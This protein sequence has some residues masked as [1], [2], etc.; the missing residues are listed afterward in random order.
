[1]YK[2]ELWCF[3]AQK[4]LLWK[5]I[6]CCYWSFFLALFWHLKAINDEDSFVFYFFFSRIYFFY[7]K[8]GLC[9]VLISTIYGEWFLIGIWIYY[10]DANNFCF[11][12]SS[13]LLS[14]SMLNVEYF[15]DFE[16]WGLKFL[17]WTGALRLWSC[18][19]TWFWHSN[20]KT[21][22]PNLKIKILT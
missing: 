19:L 22:D 8:T 7:F 3:M 10:E 11:Y 9:V 15:N 21:L 12:R 4:R 16:I 18:V 17:N 5:F 20:L 13:W 14:I 2:C 1:M 6:C